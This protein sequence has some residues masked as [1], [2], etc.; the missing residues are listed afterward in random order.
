M[1]DMLLISDVRHLCCLCIVVGLY[2]ARG[3]RGHN[4]KHI[5]WKKNRCIHTLYLYIK[6]T[7]PL[8]DAVLGILLLNSNFL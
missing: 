4:W 6:V 7:S 3:W 1:S 5:L 2:C 8:I